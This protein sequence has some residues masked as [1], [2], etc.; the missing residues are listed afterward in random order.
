MADTKISAATAV[1]TA[2]GTD[3]YATNQGGAS[4]RT[5]LD[6]ILTYLQSKGLPV[7]RRLDTQHNNSSTTGTEVTE[8]SVTLVA[9]TYT[10][11]YYLITQAG[12]TAVGQRFGINYTGTVTRLGYFLRY[13]DT[14]TS[15]TTGIADDDSPSGAES[16]MACF[17]GRT[18][19]TTSPD[20][21]ALT[22]H[23][24]ATTDTPMIIEG[25][26]VVSD[27]GD[28]ELWHSPDAAVQTSIMV[29]SSLV[30]VRTDN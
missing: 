29:G 27:G 26:I 14:G 5:N 25:L 2:T 4:K 21:G 23:A 16:I 11:T 7:V 19:S 28:L 1:T 3:E 20:L 8:L 12:D 22:N 24:T 17:V 13:C 6:Q 18:E 30:L 9:G 10:F 15:A